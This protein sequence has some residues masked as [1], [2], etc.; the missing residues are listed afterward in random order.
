M[1]EMSR[2]T[3]SAVP[4]NVPL[5]FAFRVGE[6]DTGTSTAAIGVCMTSAIGC[7]RALME[8]LRR[9]FGIGPACTAVAANSAAT[10]AQRVTRRSRAAQLEEKFGITQPPAWVRRERQRGRVL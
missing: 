9:P 3:L 5:T 1:R 2:S 4:A 8:T 6:T 7:S 10:R